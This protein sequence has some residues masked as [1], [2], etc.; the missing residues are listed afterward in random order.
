MHLKDFKGNY[1]SIYHVDVEPSTEGFED[2][3]IVFTPVWNNYF[4]KT[5]LPNL[6][7][8]L[9]TYIIHTPLT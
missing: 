4:N 8:L 7:S 5:L 3:Q 9:Y 6:L 2:T 1:L